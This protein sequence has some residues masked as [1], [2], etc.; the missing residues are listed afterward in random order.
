MNSTNDKQFPGFLVINSGGSLKGVTYKPLMLSDIFERFENKTGT[1]TQISIDRYTDMMFM[2][3]P[4]TIIQHISSEKQYVKDAISECK[5]FVDQHRKEIG[6]SIPSENDLEEKMGGY[7]SS[8]DLEK[9]D[10]CPKIINKFEEAEVLLGKDAY[11]NIQVWRR[12]QDDI[13]APSIFYLDVLL[14]ILRKEIEESLI[15][16]RPHHKQWNAVS[17]KAEET[18]PV[19]LEIFGKDDLM[20]YVVSYV[21]IL[22]KNRCFSS[23]NEDIPGYRTVSPLIPFS[24]YEPFR[25]EMED[26]V[27]QFALY[28]LKGTQPFHVGVSVSDVAS[29]VYLYNKMKNALYAHEEHL[30]YM[31]NENIY[32]YA[33]E[34]DNISTKDVRTKLCRDFL[35]YDKSNEIMGY[36]KLFPIEKWHDLEENDLSPTTEED[37]EMSTGKVPSIVTKTA[38]FHNLGKYI[39]GSYK[40]FKLYEWLSVLIPSFVHSVKTNHLNPFWKFMR[41]R[42]YFYI[43]QQLVVSSDP[44]R[45][46]PIIKVLRDTANTVNPGLFPNLKDFLQPF[47]HIPKFEHTTRSVMRE[48]NTDLPLTEVFQDDVKNTGVFIRK[49]ERVLIDRPSSH[50]NTTLPPSKR[51]KTI[52]SQ[53]IG[54]KSV[55]DVKRYIEIHDWNYDTKRVITKEKDL[56]VWERRKAFIQLTSYPHWFLSQKITISQPTTSERVYQSFKVKSGTDN[57]E[58]VAFAF[59]PFP[60]SIEPSKSALAIDFF[61]VCLRDKHVSSNMY[62]INNI[63]TRQGETAYTII[64]IPLSSDDKAFKLSEWVQMK[65]TITPDK[66]QQLNIDKGLVKQFFISLLTFKRFVPDDVIIITRPSESYVLFDDI[67]WGT[68]NS[69]TPKY[70]GDMSFVLDY[71]SLCDDYIKDYLKSLCIESEA[72]IIPFLKQ[73]GTT[74]KNLMNRSPVFID[75]YASVYEMLQICSMT[76]ASIGYIKFVT[77]WMF[78]YVPYSK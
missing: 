28:Y 77:Q 72:E 24:L 21:R 58:R 66:R 71:T 64:M 33:L 19:L 26:L 34:G 39:F 3:L 10:E 1:L 65:E 7:A 75:V 13:E 17:E 76:I 62:S 11:E 8:E 56:T 31:Y 15:D 59:R 36:D 37:E 70:R 69:L 47:L 18:T 25:K 50:N 20:Y 51:Q 53:N 2:M 38:T 60:S 54:G 12:F 78:A 9:Y 68:R 14:R 4:Y 52:L 5:W 42:W 73:A 74:L 27:G 23:G 35:I 41:I 43:F 63:Q 32:N 46:H 40:M 57:D 49:R 44:F 45:P 6:Q 16:A 61:R 48:S 55:I 67:R 29:R 30:V 22:Y